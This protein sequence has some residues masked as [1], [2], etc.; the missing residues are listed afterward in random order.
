MEW[1]DETHK[2]K[3]KWPHK[4]RWERFRIVVRSLSIRRLIEELVD[5][6]WPEKGTEQN[7][8]GQAYVKA[9]GPPVLGR[10]GCL[11]F[12]LSAGLTPYFLLPFQPSSGLVS[13]LHP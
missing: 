13:Y 1:L 8:W 4:L 11:P 3:T 7:L 6:F 9:S 5:S 2:E 12:P 10:I